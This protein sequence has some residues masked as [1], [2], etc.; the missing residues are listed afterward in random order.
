MIASVIWM[1]YSHF[2]ILKK[3]VFK[4]LNLL[5][6][7]LSSFFS[8]LLSFVVRSLFLLMK[9]II[10]FVSSDPCKNSV[11]NIVFYRCC[12]RSQCSRRTMTIYQ[13]MSI[14]EIIRKQP[15][16]IQTTFWHM[17]MGNQ[18]LEF[19]ITSAPMVHIDGT[20]IWRHPGMMILS[21]SYFYV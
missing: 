3:A 19:K 14:L 13:K 10:C 2:S 1:V 21:T 4:G 5:E 15:V 7:S 12:N 11:T 9:W 16:V 17:E 20:T 8:L 18:L 6:V